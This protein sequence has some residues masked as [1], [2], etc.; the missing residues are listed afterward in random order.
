MFKNALLAFFFALVLLGGQAAMAARCI[1]QET[2]TTKHLLD[3]IHA[4]KA[5]KKLY[6][7]YFGAKAARAFGQVMLYEHLMLPFALPLDWK[8]QPFL[9]AG[10]PLYKGDLVSIALTPSFSN[11]PVTIQDFEQPDAARV[12]KELKQELKVA[13]ENDLR[14]ADANFTQG[15]ELLH[16][17]IATLLGT[18]HVNCLQRHFLESMALSLTNAKSYDLEAA[19]QGLKSTLP[20]S[21]K[22]ALVHLQ[23]LSIMANLDRKAY[24]F[25]K[26]GIPLFCQDVPPIL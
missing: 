3:A 12:V 18:P 13:I 24:P 11:N 8:A 20:L 17:K 14:N 26:E 10:I 19:K 9:C 23:A 1:Y 22:F 16:R 25:Q 21:A 7:K 5:R 2:P 6:R 4:N 15:L